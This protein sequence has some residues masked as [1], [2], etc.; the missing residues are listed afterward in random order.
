M[1]AVLCA[2][3]G[4]PSS[5]E[6]L[7]K[8]RQGVATRV[9]SRHMSGAMNECLPLE[10]VS[11][12]KYIQKTRQGR[13]MGGPPEVEAWVAEGGYEVA[14][15]RETKSG[16]RYRKFMEY[17]DGNPLD[18]RILWTTR[19]VYVILWGV[20]GPRSDADEFAAAVQGVL[21]SAQDGQEWPEEMPDRARRQVIPGDGKCVYWALSAVDRTGGQAAAD[22]VH[23]A[24]TEG[25]MARPPELRWAQRIMWDA[26][27]RTWEQY[28][29]KVGKGEICGGACEVRRSAQ[30]RGCKVAM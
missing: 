21:D 25:V 6:E 20:R 2:L 26:G 23:K 1:W 7:Q 13:R 11:W 17:A 15:Y 18:A 5:E 10:K 29:D 9:E 22:K 19:G 14:V 8:M 27:V 12:Q 3:E 4:R 24:L 16:E 28:L 30:S